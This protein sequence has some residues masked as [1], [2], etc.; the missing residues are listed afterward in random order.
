M[1]SSIESP[2]LGSKDVKKERERLPNFTAEDE[3]ILV[4]EAIRRIDALTATA[5]TK[6]AKQAKEQAWQE[7]TDALN[8]RSTSGIQRNYKN[9]RDKWTNERID[10]KKR[11]NDIKK[12][13]KGTGGGKAPKP[14]KPAQ[15]MILDALKNSAAF[16]GLTGS[17]S[18]LGESSPAASSSSLSTI[19]PKPAYLVDTEEL[20]EW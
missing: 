3:A 12:A 6:D 2:K 9:V 10:T 17:E 15:E 13:A 5:N 18:P 16:S 8:A 1:D 14:L 19:P 4:E 20:S 11:F 7:V